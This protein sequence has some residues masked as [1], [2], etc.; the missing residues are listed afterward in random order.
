[1][2]A[3]RYQKRMSGLDVLQ[4]KERHVIGIL[5][6]GFS[7]PHVHI[8]LVPINKLNDLNPVREQAIGSADADRLAAKLRAALLAGDA[9]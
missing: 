3:T 4:R 2:V 1:M 9:E 7:V 8:H 6:E 5:V